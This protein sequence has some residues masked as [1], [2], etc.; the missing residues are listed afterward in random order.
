MAALL[1]QVKSLGINVTFGMKVIDYFDNSEKQRAGVILEN[2]EKIEA[3]IVV[4]ADGIGTKS[5]KLV[6]GGD[7]RAYSSG[8]SIF[9]TSFPAELT[10][11]DHEIRNRWPL[12]EGGIPHLEIWGG[13][14]ATV[15]LSVYWGNY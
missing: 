15:V 4:A 11:S 1:S 2:G 13:Y 12:L 8:I 10:M 6:N 14:V 3:D 5:N 7:D 9:R